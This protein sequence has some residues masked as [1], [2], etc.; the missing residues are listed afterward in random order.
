M[1]P[2]TPTVARTSISPA[3][4][5][6]KKKER[7]TS[8]PNE[9]PRQKATHTRESAHFLQINT[10][11]APT[12]FLQCTKSRSP[13]PGCSTLL[14]TSSGGGGLAGGDPKNSGA[15]RQHTFSHR[16]CDR[17]TTLSTEKSSLQPTMKR[18][19]DHKITGGE[20]KSSQEQVD[21]GSKKK[22]IKW[23]EMT[24]AFHETGD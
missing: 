14:L 19:G 8:Q 5:T 18:K 16:P 24:K 12:H 11:L 4:V 7:P 3:V 21:H 1:A 20:S 10:P 13:A 9:E 6:P 15:E 22:E 2:S 23:T 17:T